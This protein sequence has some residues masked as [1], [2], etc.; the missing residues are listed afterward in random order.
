MRASYVG[1]MSSPLVYVIERGCFNGSAEYA[2]TS[3][4]RERNRGNAKPA[5]T[6][7]PV[8]AWDRFVYREPEETL[9]HQAHR[10]AC[11]GKGDPGTD[12][13]GCSDATLTRR[14]MVV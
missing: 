13:A 12:V 7:W 9:S 1:L 2:E 10:N 8:P 4:R 6:D 11:H 3:S 5:G 14:T